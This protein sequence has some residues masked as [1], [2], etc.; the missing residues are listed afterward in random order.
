MQTVAIIDDNPV[1]R[2]AVT[3][4]LQVED[5]NTVEFPSCSGVQEFTRKEKVDLMLVDVQLPDGNGFN[6]V[7]EVRHYSDVPVIFLT[8]RSEESDRILGFEVGADDY[9]L[10]PFS[11]KE[12]V[13]RIKA[14]LK[15]Q[16]KTAGTEKS[17]S[18]KLWQSGDSI[19]NFNQPAHKFFL[20]TVEVKFTSTEWK[21]ISY[22]I[23]NAQVVV[24]REQI[25]DHSLEYH[26]DGYDRIVD[27]HIKNIRAKL[28][29]ADWIETVRGYGYS[30]TGKNCG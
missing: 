8:S 5:F 29:S 28:G 26:F 21:I 7:K 3:S 12:L 25:L 1:I 13:L 22:L 19:I 11:C 18:G 24:S 15:R 17:E 14:V 10:K 23:S 2:E 20:D 6:L 4:Y 30:F 27:T 16:T 9:M